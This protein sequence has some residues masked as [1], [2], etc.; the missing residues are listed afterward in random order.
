[1]TRLQRALLAGVTL[2]SLL[3]ATAITASA[4]GY[5]YGNTS[6]NLY[7]QS[8]VRFTRPFFTIDASGGPN[9]CQAG[10]HVNQTMWLSSKANQPVLLG[11]NMRYSWLEV[12]FLGGLNLGFPRQVGCDGDRQL[13]LPR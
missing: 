10:H 8:Y 2:A 11:G 3:F 6:G 9:S 1:M 5:S 7:V 4:A 13:R 12:G